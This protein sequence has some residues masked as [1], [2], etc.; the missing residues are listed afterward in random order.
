[1]KIEMFKP[2]DFHYHPFHNNLITEYFQKSMLYA[3][4]GRYA[5][6]HI[7]KALGVRKKILLPCYICETVLIPLRELNIEAVYYEL[8]ERDLNCDMNSLKEVLTRD[9]EIEAVL[10]ASMYGNPADL[11]AAEK[12]CRDFGVFLIDDAAQSVGAELAGRKVGTFGDAGF[13]ALSPGKPLAGHMGAFFRVNRSYSIQYRKNRLYHMVAWLNFYFNRLKVYK[14][15]SFK[16]R[17]ILTRAESFLSRRKSIRND[18]YSTFEKKILGGILTTHFTGDFN[19]RNEMF[20]EFL[21]RF[22]HAGLFQVIDTLRGRSHPHK[23]VIKFPCKEKAE[24]FF[25]YLRGEGISALRGY[26]LLPEHG[27]EKSRKIAASVVEL[28]LEAHKGRMEYLFNR[29]EN[30]CKNSVIERIH[31]G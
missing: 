2:A 23:L 17:A 24:E 18:F 16:P 21:K 28:P 31:E 20:R 30:Y 10:I 13:F 27:F 26:T 29:V 15:N 8:D 11:I 12:I 5:L 19:F 6:Y 14:W 25:H 7:L 9:S 22:K 3:S 4:K 1:M